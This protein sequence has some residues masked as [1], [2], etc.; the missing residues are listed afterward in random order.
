MLLHGYV[1]RAPRMY[2]LQITISLI[3]VLLNTIK[4]WACIFF[5]WY[6]III[7]CITLTAGVIFAFLE[8]EFFFAYKTFHLNNR[9]PNAIKCV[10][11][12]TSTGKS[13]WFFF[14]NIE[15]PRYNNR[16][17]LL[18]NNDLVAEINPRTVLS[19][20]YI[21]RPLTTPDAIHRS[22]PF[23]IVEPVRGNGRALWPRNKPKDSYYNMVTRACDSGSRLIKDTVNCI[24]HVYT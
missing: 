21:S 17:R 6:Y 4:D 23:T 24:T 19:Q 11:S 8:N 18:C 20:K 1:Y 13:C 10:R 3:I 7:I 15:F 22:F 12:I 9:I 14:S 5:H 16:G 2:N